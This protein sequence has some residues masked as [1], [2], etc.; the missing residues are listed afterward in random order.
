MN[1][2]KASSWKNSKNQLL[3]IL[4]GSFLGVVPVL[5]FILFVFYN[6]RSQE[7]VQ[8]ERENYT[9]EIAIQL[10]R[11]IDNIQNSYANEINE[12]SS[13][14]SSLTPSKLEQVKE[15][16]PTARTPNIIC[17]PRKANSSILRVKNIRWAIPISSKMLPTLRP[18]KS[19]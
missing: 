12:G 19:Y 7:A 1:L 15:A 17:L 3:S 18:T 2:V 10:T 8:A 4:V 13:A 5:G 6:N 9:S 14:L 11:N 16:F